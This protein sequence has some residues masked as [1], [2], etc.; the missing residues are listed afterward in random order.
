MYN[1]GCTGEAYTGCT[2]VVYLGVYPGWYVQGGVP[3][4]CT[5]GGMLGRH[6]AQRGLSGP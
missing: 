2:M 6:E 5:Q 4:G 1:G 3:R